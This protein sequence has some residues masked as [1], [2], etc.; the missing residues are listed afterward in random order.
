MK[1]LMI[2]AYHFPPGGGPGVQRVLKHITYLPEFGWEPIVVTVKDGDF[3]ARDESLLAKIPHGVKV[4]RIPIIEPYNIYRLITGKRGSAIDVNVNKNESPSSGWKDRLGNWIRATFFIPDARMGWMLNAPRLAAKIAR[5]EGVSVVYTSSPP[6]T[7][8]L[9]GRSVKRRTKLPWIAGFR[10]PWTGFLTSPKRSKFP[11]MID[12]Y[13]EKSVFT[14]ADAIECAWQGIAEDAYRKYPTLN[15]SKFHH[16]PNGFD[17]ADF[18]PDPNSPT[19][20]F[21]VTYTGSMYG[22]RTPDSFLKA[23]ERLFDKE[24]I[25]PQEVNIRFI[26]RFGDEVHEMFRSS[27]FSS[28]IETVS[29]VPH[30]K[31]IE[32]LMASDLLLLVV[33]QAKESHAIVPGKVF[34]YLGT[35]RPILALCPNGSAVEQLIVNTNAGVSVQQEDIEAIAG[36]LTGMIERYR[37]KEPLSNPNTEVINIYER[38]EGAR[39]L[40]SLLNRLTETNT[41]ADSHEH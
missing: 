5:Q 11:S 18:P 14:E 31:S 6:Y 27:S 21:T 17:S 7:C 20:K 34:E 10:D 16:I 35:K 8:A 36:A 30:S 23:L 33:D 3:P 2:I 25:K 38:R 40:A 4:F 41:A 37:R 15:K 12:R 24:V 22:H 39:A 29:Y 26:G 28:V 13:L 1:R 19:D 9:V 32:Y